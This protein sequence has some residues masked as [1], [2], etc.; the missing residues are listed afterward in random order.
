MRLIKNFFQEQLFSGVLFW[1][2]VG[3]RVSIRQQRYCNSS[4]V[5]TAN[6]KQGSI[7]HDT[8]KNVFMC[9]TSYLGTELL[10]F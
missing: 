9:R 1:F 7:K 2:L 3:S 4:F 6:P 10:R 8:G 5:Q